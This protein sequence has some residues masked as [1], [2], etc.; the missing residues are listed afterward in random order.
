MVSNGEIPAVLTIDFESFYVQTSRRMLPLA[1]SLTG[2]WGDAEDL[3]QEAYIAAHRHWK[4]VGA[5]DDP[6][7]WV[8][9]VIT[10]S[11]LSRWRRLGREFNVRQRLAARTREESRVD[12]PV[13]EEF[14]Q[15]VRALPRQ[16]AAVVAL[17]YTEDGSGQVIG[18]PSLS[19]MRS[20]GTRN[21][22]PNRSTGIPLAPLLASYLRASR[23]AAVRPRRS[24]S[25]AS[26][27]VR[28]SGA[29]LGV[30]GELSFISL[31]NS[32]PQATVS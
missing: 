32:T 29:L 14:W 1:F 11:S 24:T 6:T 22:L 19:S 5:Y 8:R 25:A 3:V 16:Q 4:K 17:Y 31:T 7:A 30:V 2:S 28:K 13:D 23:Y 9:R 10:N 15:A 20:R 18:P 12:E 26:S 21:C 27:T